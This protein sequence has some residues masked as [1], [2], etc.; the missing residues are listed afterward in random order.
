ME[1]HQVK[2]KDGNNDISKTSEIIENFR[3]LNME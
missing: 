2:V 1:E 3:V